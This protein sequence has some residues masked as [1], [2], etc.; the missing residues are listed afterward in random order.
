M[1]W[2]NQYA[3]CSQPCSSAGLPDELWRLPA[4]V[5]SCSENGRKEADKSVSVPLALTLTLALGLTAEAI[6]KGID[7][8]HRRRRNWISC[9]GM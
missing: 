1:R 2:A 7:F 5:D 9:C 8:L 6:E 4:R 3:L